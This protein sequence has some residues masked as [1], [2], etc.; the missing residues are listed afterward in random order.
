MIHFSKQNLDKNSN[1]QIKLNDSSIQ[2]KYIFLF[3]LLSNAVFLIRNFLIAAIVKMTINDSIKS[4]NCFFKA[5]NGQLIHKS[6]N[7]YCKML[8]LCLY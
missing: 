7:K 4:E 1:S 3:N 6:G 2:I 8:S 5:N